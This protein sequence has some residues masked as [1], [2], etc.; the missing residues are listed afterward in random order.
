LAGNWIEMIEDQGKLQIRKKSKFLSLSIIIVSALLMHT[1]IVLTSKEGETSKELILIINVDT[2]RY[3]KLGVYGNDRNLTPHLDEL[4][5]KEGVIFHQAYAASNHTRPSVV[6]L[7]TGTYPTNHGFWHHKSE[8]KIKKPNIATVMPDDYTTILVN[9]NPNTVFI[10]ADHFDYSWSKYPAEDPKYA[11]C[12][13][14]PAEYIFN[15]A[16]DF[17][18]EANFPDKVLL[19]I[20]PA[21]P[22]D[23]YYPLKKYPDLFE[24]DKY[25]DKYTGRYKSELCDL[26]WDENLAKRTDAEIKNLKNRYDAEVRYLDEQMHLFWQFISKKYQKILFIFTSDHGE[27]FLDHNDASHGTSL[28]NEQIKIPFI[29][30]DAEKRFGKP[31]STDVLISNVDILPTIAEVVRYQKELEVDG[32][33]LFKIM[34]YFKKLFPLK[35]N[36]VIISEVVHSSEIIDVDTIKDEKVKEI[37]NFYK[38]NPLNA[39]VRANIKY[40]NSFF[41]N[42]VYKY[43]KNE[44]LYETKILLLFRKIFFQTHYNEFYRIDLDT[45]ER[46]NLLNGKFKIARHIYDSSPLKG[47]YPKFYARHK[48]LSKEE[49]ERLKT[50]GYIR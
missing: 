41:K 22:H 43:I 25:K 11:D 33:S 46:N 28:Y 8:I 17:L 16:C 26:R 5:K 3:D 6:S 38:N 18:K 13:Y 4:A 14:Y 12:A 7:F 9:A 29:I 24:G 37:L 15:K 23:P 35:K 40:T 42:A 19:Y 50:L 48:K 31:R 36:R 27:S 1:S 10:F 32:E 44:S 2:L 45:K 20:Q 30:I 21:D 49:I 47:I 34:S 39:L